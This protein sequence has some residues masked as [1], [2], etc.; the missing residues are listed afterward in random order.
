LYESPFDDLKPFS[1]LAPE[2]TCCLGVN[3]DTGAVPDPDV[4]MDCLRAGFDEVLAG[5]G[6]APRMRCC[7]PA[8]RRRRRTRPTSS[9]RIISTRI[10]MILAAHG[11]PSWSSHVECL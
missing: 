10:E 3:V 7:R 11:D 1:V 4:V 6:A 5:W 9:S 8:P 2:D